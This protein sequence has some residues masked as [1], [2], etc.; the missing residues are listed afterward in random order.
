MKIIPAIDII[1]GQ[2]VRLSQGDYNSKTIYNSNPLNVAK[3]FEDIGF[4]YLHLVDLD[5]AK[6]GRIVNQNILEQITSKTTLSVDFGGGVKSD[7][8]IRIA[9]EAGAKQV[10]CGSIA[11]KRPE[12]VLKWIEKYGVDKLILGADVRNKMI[13]ISGWTETTNL[14]I[15]QFLSIYLP[16]GLNTII[17]TDIATDGM[18]L[19]PNTALYSELMNR[20]SEI[21]LIASGGISSIEDII[22]L[23]AMG[24]TGAIIGK[25]IYENKIDLKE[26]SKYA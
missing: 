22:Q 3:S 11:V 6:K 16:T 12:E 9:F 23:R 24:L 26:L 4:K 19:G 7:N 18:L 5:G 1:N 8:D 14:S 25:A 17:C 21:K 2:C 13:A 20:F 10:I 15:D